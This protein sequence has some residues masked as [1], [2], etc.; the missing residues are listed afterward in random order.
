MRRATSYGDGLQEIGGYEATVQGQATAMRD[1]IAAV[2]QVPNGK[3]LGIFYWEPEW[4]PVE[5]AGWKT[6]QG[7]TWENQAMFDFHG[8]ALP[9]L[10]VFRL[11]RPEEGGKIIPARSW[12]YSLRMPKCPWMGSSNSRPP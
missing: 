9:S 5:G 4:I 12:N 10:N 3:G 11:V 7:D 8:N 2:A 1:V 6:G